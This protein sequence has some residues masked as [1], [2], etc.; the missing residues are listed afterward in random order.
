VTA[1]PLAGSEAAAPAVTDTASVDI[2]PLTTD[3]L[4]AIP[5]ADTA[6]TGITTASTASSA[7][8]PSTVS[9]PSVAETAQATGLESKIVELVPALAFQANVG[10]DSL[11]GGAGAASTE[12]TLVQNEE[13][14]VM[15]AEEAAKHEERLARSREETKGGKTEKGVGALM[16]GRAAS[17]L[18][19]GGRSASLQSSA[20][21]WLD[22]LQ[23][24]VNPNNLSDM[25]G[26]EGGGPQV[27]VSFANTDGIA[28]M[29][30][31][32]Q[33]SQETGGLTGQSPK[34]L[35]AYGH[36]K[37]NVVFITVIE[38]DALGTPL[39]AARLYADG[40]IKVY[41]Q[42]ERKDLKASSSLFSRRQIL[43]SKVTDSESGDGYQITGV[44]KASKVSQFFLDKNR[45]T[46][47][48][49]CP[50][51]FSKK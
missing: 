1:A 45:G 12:N 10:A 28:K 30:E 39:K 20:T 36:D 2:A 19:G 47:R 40:R 46:F 23:S 5:S 34:T 6:T 31:R 4:V 25:G 33:A 14:M 29:I 38:L 37:D 17:A 43:F 27:C 18:L 42:L 22:A 35:Y 15:K 48:A 26:Q 50:K 16:T 32:G 11:V 51:A 41:G 9:T 44:L 49:P 21:G 8:T 3:V 13:L 24:S 7:A